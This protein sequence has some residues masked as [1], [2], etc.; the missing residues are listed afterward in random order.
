MSTK[1]LSLISALFVTSLLVSNIIASKIASFGPYFLPAAVIIF[2]ITYIL[3]DILTEVYGY[4]AMRRCIWTG[5]LCNLFAVIVYTIASMLPAAP[6]YADQSAFATIFGAAPRMLIAS[7]I[8]YLIGSFTNAYILAKLKMRTKGRFLWLRT[9]VSTLVGEGLDSSIFISIAFSSIFPWSQVGV[10]ICT[11]WI[12]KCA[13]EILA[14]PLTYAIVIGIKKK[15][16]IDHFDHTT[17]FQPF[18]L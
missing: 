11:Q 6:F 16:G 8:A 9:I 18:T 17:N 3:A 7:Y 14:T 15:E 4:A 12:F 5:F 1:Y 2:P 13:I 10:M